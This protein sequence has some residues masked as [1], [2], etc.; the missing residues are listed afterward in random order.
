MI[1]SFN[2][3]KSFLKAN[4]TAKITYLGIVA[5]ALFLAS[6]ALSR[7]K[8]FG[9]HISLLVAGLDLIAAYL[10][11]DNGLLYLRGKPTGR[12]L[13]I[14]ISLGAG[15]YYYFHIKYGFMNIL[16]LLLCAKT[17][18]MMFLPK[19]RAHIVKPKKVPR[20]NKSYS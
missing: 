4:S 10:V 12:T 18:I 11:L 13:A 2:P 6:F 19:A 8:F 7:G 3:K 1:I 17:T 20:S 15:V 9:A 16:A 14:L 5:Q